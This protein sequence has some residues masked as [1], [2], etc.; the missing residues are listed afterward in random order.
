MRAHV[1]SEACQDLVVKGMRFFRASAAKLFPEMLSLA[2]Q[3]ITAYP[4]SVYKKNFS[5]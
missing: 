1:S 2:K 3:G 4:R 5:G